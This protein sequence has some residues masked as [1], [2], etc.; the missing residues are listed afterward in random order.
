MSA[1]LTMNVAPIEVEDREL[2]VGVYKYEGKDQLAELRSCHSNTHVF[3]REGGTE[4]LAVP[5]VQN[6]PHLGE[7]TRTLTLGT[8]LPLAAALVRNALMQF[9]LALPR[10]V[11]RFDPLS[12][13]ADPVKDNLLIQC[14]PSGAACP[15]WLGVLPLYELSVRKFSLVPE[16]ESLGVAFCVRTKKRI[17]QQL[18]DSHRR[19]TRCDWKVCRQMGATCGFTN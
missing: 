19:W 17:R 10:R 6:A 1:R 8:H 12:F 14:L 11:T 2:S 3:R 9:I 13:L 7:L 15:E 16:K 18:S 4:L 5:Y